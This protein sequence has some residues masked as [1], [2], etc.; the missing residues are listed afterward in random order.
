MGEGEGGGEKVE[1]ISPLPVIPSHQGKGKFI[2]EM[3]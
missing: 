2:E 3:K 1:L